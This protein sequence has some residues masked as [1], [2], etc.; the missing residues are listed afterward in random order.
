MLSDD[1]QERGEALS[2][3]RTI[4]PPAA[5]PALR[6][7]LIALLERQNQDVKQSRDFGG[8]PLEGPEFRASLQ[9][10]AAE[11]REPNAI[12]ALAGALGMFTA[13]RALA[14]F[15]EQAVPAVVDAVTSP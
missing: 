12:P 15:G 9:H 2:A 3:A 14:R 10:M 4:R 11:L 8:M 13:I 7:A 1:K 5:G 6:A